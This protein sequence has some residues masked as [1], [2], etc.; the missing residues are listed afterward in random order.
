MKNTK[1][2][3]IPLSKLN[4]L[5]QFIRGSILG[6]GSIPKQEKKSKNYRMTFGHGF[7]Q[8]AYLEWKH[9]FLENYLL[10]GSMQI[11]IAKSERY[12]TGE[13]ISYHFKSKTHPI[14]TKFRKLYYE[15]IKKLDKEDIMKM[16][17]FALAIWYMD[18]GNISKPKKKSSHIELNTQSFI[19]E[20]VDLLID[21]LQ[22]KWNIKCARM[23]YSNIIRISCY[24]CQ[25]FLDLIEPYKV[26]CLSYKWVLH[27]EEELLES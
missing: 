17:E 23:T 25:K 21:I 6:D 24:D 8:K 22:T 16:D 10:S 5:E 9:A 27:K 14:F 13:C 15:N 19:V 1:Y 2:P 20:D 11:V 12:K 26:D 7:K 18:D 4:M 3:E